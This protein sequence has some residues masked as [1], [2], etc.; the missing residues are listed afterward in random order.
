M[1]AFRQLFGSS[2]EDI[3]QELADQVGGN[4][5][6]GGFWLPD[7][8]EA[9]YRDW[10]I[11]LD[12]GVV[13]TGKTIFVYT[14]LRAPFTN[15]DDFRFSVQRKH[16][17]HNLGLLL[18][19]QGIQTGY[20]EFDAHYTIQANDEKKAKQLFANATIRHLI[21]RQRNIRLQIVPVSR[22]LF[23]PAPSAEA[24]V[25]YFKA[26][27]VIKDLERLKLLYDLFA[28]TLNQLCLMESSYANELEQ[29]V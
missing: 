18:G 19:M 22:G 4:F 5:T 8:V 7:K 14:R 15:T 3:W 24:S 25:L 10:T 28:A 16:I 11:V 9:H 1:G 27:G 17:F 13:S 26:R 2:K 6:Y 29:S 20:P 23:Q 21:Q 12:T